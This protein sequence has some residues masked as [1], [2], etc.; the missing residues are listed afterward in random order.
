MMTEPTPE[1]LEACRK[2]LIDEG[3]EFCT[4]YEDHSLAVFVQ[5]REQAARL[6]EA[7]WW[8]NMPPL[9]QPGSY[10]AVEGDKRIAAL[11]P[12]EPRG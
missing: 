8:R 11:E 10:F 12:K 9:V 5:A 3:L 7:K 2:W 4:G 1:L 6:D